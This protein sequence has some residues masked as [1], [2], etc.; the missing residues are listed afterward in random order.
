MSFAAGRRVRTPTVLQMEAVECGAACLGSMLAYYGRWVA[1][2]ELRL[3]CGVSRDGS[4]AKNVVA[5][6][7]HYGL[8]AKGRRIDLTQA[9]T[10]EPPYVVFW[11]LNHFV[12][13]EGCRR[14]TVHLNDPASGPRKVSV[15]DFS[16]GFSGIV[17][18]MKPNESF[19]PAGS[20]PSLLRSLA[21]RIRGSEDALVYVL[22]VTLFLVVP[23]LI[24]PA[25]LKAFVDD[26]LGMRAYEWVFPVLVTLL[27]AMAASGVL[28]WIQQKQ[29]LRMEMKLSITTAGQFFWHALRLPAAFYTQRYTGD[30]VDRLQSCHRIAQLL[31]GSVSTNAANSIV[32]VFYLAVML[33]YSV[34]LALIA[35]S[36][37]LLNGAAAALANRRRQDLSSN[38]LNERAKLSGSAMNGLQAIEALKSSGD[39]AA[40]FDQWSGHQTKLTNEDQRLG[41]ITACLG[42]VPSA[43]H[44][45]GKVLVLSVGALLI[46]DGRLSIGGLVAFQLLM[47]QFS[48]P[49][50]ALIGFAARL[51]EARGDL[52]RLDDVLHYPLD[53][54]ILGE[55]EGAHR[56]VAPAGQ[57]SGRIELRNVSFR[58][59]PFGPEVV[60]N[61]SLEIQPG[62]RVALVGASG[63]GK[64]TLARLLVGLYHPTE[65]DVLYDGEPI[66]AI[67]RDV[68]T[69]SV[70]AVDQDV[71]MIEGSIRDNLTLWDSTI[72]D[73]A[74]VRAA[75]DASI[76]D[77][78]ASRPNGYEGPVA[79]AGR[80]FSG[81]QRQRL[82]IARALA[83]DPT[84]CVLDEATAT[85]DAVTEQKIDDRLRRRGCTCVIVAHRL[86]TIRD[87]DEIVVLAHGEIKER[88]TH[89]QLMARRG[90]YAQLV[91]E[92]LV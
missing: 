58:H 26:V 64:S 74:V 19:V 44:Q 85:L 51:Q 31:S 88:G 6:A 5:A 45:L 25:L 1:L 53:E 20:P 21:A 11:N 66:A 70:S 38:L 29:L 57:L 75:R 2:E 18:E 60:R 43:L 28:T 16:D 46:I 17:L 40:F 79:E 78:I 86:S 80:N 24:V 23:G 3:M 37:A 69:A 91:A 89:D 73:D 71:T 92:P 42:A 52:N 30:V 76:H 15:K 83:G 4:N 36:V 62:A 81:G 77:V 13:F 55:R 50:S 7:Q 63:S 34:P 84:V 54:I 47:A 48:N 27:L 72:S 59:S 33:S 49:I 65:G 87:C 90:L 22:A 9:L 68:F 67:D 14:D 12:V 35:V 10:L 39:E 61:V 32:V 41:E 82:E 56:G 8:D